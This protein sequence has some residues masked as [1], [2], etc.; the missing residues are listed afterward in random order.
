MNAT[1]I[2]DPLA[3]LRRRIGWL[4]A[5]A[6]MDAPVERLRIQ[7]HLEALHDDDASLLAAA[8]DEFEEKLAQLRTRLAVAENSVFADL[9]NDWETFAA[10]VER[11]LRGWHTY[12]EQLEV[13]AFP[14]SC[15]P[16]EQAEAEIAD[17]CMRLV[18]AD[19]SAGIHWQEQRERVTAARDQLEEKVAHLSATLD[20]SVDRAAA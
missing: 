18:H 4:Q 9:A 10:G 2:D 20:R 6:E 17:A 14:R 3:G 7:R 16:R 19:T 12:L 11:E 15:E 8:P 5:L 13:S 1:T